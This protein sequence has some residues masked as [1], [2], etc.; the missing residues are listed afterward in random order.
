[1]EGDGGIGREVVA[2]WLERLFPLVA[3]PVVVGCLLP[4]GGVGDPAFWASVLGFSVLLGLLTVPS[5]T[6]R[7]IVGPSTVRVHYVVSEL[8]IPRCSVVGVRP[9]GRATSIE[10]AGTVLGEHGVVGPRVAMP[11]SLR[12]RALRVAEALEVPRVRPTV[13][14]RPA[15]KAMGAAIPFLMVV[16]IVFGA[17]RPDLEPRLTD[18][19]FALTD[20]SDE[21]AADVAAG[22]MTADEAF[23]EIERQRAE[24]E[25]KVDLAAFM[26]GA[27]CSAALATGAVLLDRRRNRR[28]TTADEGDGVD[29]LPVPPIDH[30]VPVE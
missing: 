26:V 30:G 3:L 8:E 5:W 28:R 4:F 16:L 29:G 25:P 2:S 14:I 19:E 27:A 22:R 12:S 15:F 18:D 1:M 9:R 20:L 17:T 24:D 21:L 7:V 10:L 23:A 11:V 6:N 13:E